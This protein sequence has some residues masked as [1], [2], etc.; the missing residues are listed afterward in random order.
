[1]VNRKKVTQPKAASNAAKT[2]KKDPSAAAKSKSTSSS[3]LSQTKA[4]KKVTGEKA[5]TDASKILKDKRTPPKAKSAAGSTL[6][7][8]LGKTN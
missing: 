6:T 3:A 5:A 7:Q 8:K 4:P 2:L 1:M